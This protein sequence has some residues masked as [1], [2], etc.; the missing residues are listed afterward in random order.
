MAQPS[1]FSTLRPNRF[2]AA[3]RGAFFWLI[4]P[5]ALFVIAFGAAWALLGESRWWVGLLVN[6]APFIF[7]PAFIL[8]PFALMLRARRAALLLL[9]IVMSAVVVYGGA[10]VPR[11][12]S[13]PPPAWT[14]RVIALNVSDNLQPTERFEAWLRA[15]PADVVIL[16][17]IFAPLQGSIP[18]LRDLYPF[19]AAH[20]RHNA[21]AILSRYP[22]IEAY[23]WVVEQRGQGYPSFPR[24]TVQ[25]GDQPVRV[26]GT[27]LAAPLRLQGRVGLPDVRVP[28][29][30]ALWDM[31]LGYDDRQRRAEVST[32]L[33]WIDESPYPVIV[34]GDMN[35]VEGSADYRR[36]S[37]R[38]TD[39]YR[40]AA[41]GFGFT[42]P[43]WQA[44]GLPAVLPPL[45]RL[46]YV[47]HTPD[48][49]TLDARY[50]EYVGSDHLPVLATIGGY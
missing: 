46:D 26:I 10:F 9:P 45:M 2:A 17:E 49:V 18:R 34:A 31:V 5:Y 16:S 19:A 6:F 32:I 29:V 14:L 33:Q 20:Q 30:N 12:E 43:A 24:V 4:L 36:L 23:G 13:P 7:M 27:S 47:W 25:V 41:A 50:G 40:E 37:A 38:L 15:N 42:F 35:L 1:T 3:Q 44:F 48:L 28:G 22:I 39:S 11:R 21:V 8:L